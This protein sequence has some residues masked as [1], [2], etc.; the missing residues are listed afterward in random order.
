VKGY[1]GTNT[2]CIGVQEALLRNIDAGLMRTA[3]AGGGPSLIIGGGGAAR[4][5]GYALRKWLGDERV[6]VM[7]RPASEV[8]DVKEGSRK[9]KEMLGQMSPVLLCTWNL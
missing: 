2:G 3:K 6:Y 5:A 4:S 1:I 8:E 7:N 9:L